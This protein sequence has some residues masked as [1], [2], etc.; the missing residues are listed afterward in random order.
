MVIPNR[1]RRKIGF[2]ILKTYTEELEKKDGK[3][4]K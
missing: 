4:K 1:A 3:Q 2:V